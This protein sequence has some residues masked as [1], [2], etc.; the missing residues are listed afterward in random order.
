[1]D[2]SIGIQQKERVKVRKQMRARIRKVHDVLY[3]Y[4]H[5]KMKYFVSVKE[6]A[7]IFSFMQVI[8]NETQEDDQ[9]EAMEQLLNDC[10]AVLQ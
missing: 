1:M 8:D 6:L 5:E 3:K 7:Y 4:S 9:R 10:Q 2:L